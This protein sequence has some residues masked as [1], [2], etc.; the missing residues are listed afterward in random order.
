MD[1][2]LIRNILNIVLI[3]WGIVLPVLLL[4]AKKVLKKIDEAWADDKV[5]NEEM[6]AIIDAAMGRGD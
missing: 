3:V 2:E 4:R 6:T 5:T 1:L